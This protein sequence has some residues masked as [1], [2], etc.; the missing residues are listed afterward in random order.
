[1]LKQRLF[2]GTLLVLCVAGALGLDHTYGIDLGFTGLMLLAVLL[3]L[4]EFYTMFENTGARIPK[5]F[6]LLV[7][8]ILIAGLWLKKHFCPWLQLSF[9]LVLSMYLL[10]LSGIYLARQ[11]IN[12]VTDLAMA[13]FGIMYIYWC[14]SYLQGIRGN[15]L[16]G[17][18]LLIYFIA[19]NKMA[20]TCAYAFGSLLGRQP[21]APLISPKKTVEGF[22]G[23][24]IGG[25]LFG[26]LLWSIMPQ[27]SDCYLWH[28]MIFMGGVI[29]ISGQLSD[30]V[31]SLFKRY[32]QVRDSGHLFPGLG[33][34]LDLVDSLILSA[35]IAYYLMTV[36]MYGHL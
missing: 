6:S 32:C 8:G 19:V 27:L 12:R 9:P 34:V 22:A 24:I 15:I 20:D 30:L 29:T 35:P 23:G 1:M 25:T 33:G 10:G 36:F 16:A 31:A 13:V 18:S 21:L 3:T 28:R 14:L 5:T 7:V 11:A 26:L 2:W 17:E 4:Y